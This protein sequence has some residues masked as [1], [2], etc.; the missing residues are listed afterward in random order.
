[1][2]PKPLQH[3]RTAWQ[4]LDAQRRSALASLA[5]LAILLLTLVVYQRPETVPPAHQ[6]PQPAGLGALA[7]DDGPAAPI[8]LADP[9][10]P[11]APITPADTPEPTEPSQ[12]AGAEAAA[13]PPAADTARLSAPVDGPVQRGYGWAHFPGTGDWRI[14]GGVDFAAA[15]DTGV[16]A[17]AAGTVVAVT[18]DPLWGRTVV[19][20]H[21]AGRRTAYVGLGRV[22]VV[23]GE[24]VRRGESIGDVGAAGPLE[25]D[26]G[27]H[28]H[29]AVEVD[30]KPV[31][32]TQ[33]LE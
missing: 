3:V 26:A 21:G 33:L 13:E 6:G 18:D 23:A 15:P 24:R 19:V 31:D 8:T 1:M 4:R 25:A 28:L 20:D 30:G 11:A 10:T 14:H 22:S 29:F 27:P 9:I 2:L 17:A 16:F 32:P 5:F 12:P 7:S